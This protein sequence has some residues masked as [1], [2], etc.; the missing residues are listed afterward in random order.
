M[1][2]F[3]IDFSNLTL[4]PG[5]PSTPLAATQPRSRFEDHL[6][7]ATGGRRD[8]PAESAQP[9][10][11][12]ASAAARSNEDSTAPAGTISSAPEDEPSRIPEEAADQAAGTA[13]QQSISAGA[14]GP[15]SSQASSAGSG[16]KKPSQPSADNVEG[17][18]AKLKRKLHHAGLNG[19]S[20]SDAPQQPTSGGAAHEA[21]NIAAASEST[22]ASAISAFESAEEKIGQI[23]SQNWDANSSRADSAGLLA[24]AV[25]ER[26]ARQSGAAE[27]TPTDAVDIEST[28]GIEHSEQIDRPGGGKRTRAVKT[29]EA[30]HSPSAQQVTATLTDESSPTAA[31]PVLAAET[32]LGT[33]QLNIEVEA[34]RGEAEPGTAK[35]AA[36]SDA[37]DARPNEASLLFAARQDKS[38]ETD[39]RG[40]GLT[41]AERV[42]FV[43]RVARAF[44]SVGDEGGEVRLRLSPPELGSLRLELSVRDGVM[45]ARLEAETAAARNLLLDNLPV[46]RERLAEQNVKVEQFDVDVRDEQR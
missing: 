32:T 22:T 39:I 26:T 6:E 33:E 43:Q 29:A 12:T 10:N 18:A 15:T 16:G 37:N 34:A 24:S 46:L 11:H 36:G 14:A 27:N 9:W 13:E 8:Q 7:G 17:K 44:H 20:G 19:A 5:V 42:R 40:E 28:T 23:E 45:S 3:A 35:P 38:H 41:E 25:A 2:Q 4:P 30:N 1:R 21:S 31:I